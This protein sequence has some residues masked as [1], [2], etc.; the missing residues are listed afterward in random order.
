MWDKSGQV[1]GHDN[2][3]NKNKTNHDTTKSIQK[4]KNERIIFEQCIFQR[5][6][7]VDSGCLEAQEVKAKENHRAR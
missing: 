6:S 4:N 1:N 7:E 5:K 2:L 3:E